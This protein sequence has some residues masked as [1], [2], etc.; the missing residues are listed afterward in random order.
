MS[1]PD[2]FGMY[3]RELQKNFST[4]AAIE[5]THRLAMGEIG[6]LIPAWPIE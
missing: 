2:P 3:L 4:G 6:E 5:H 1:N